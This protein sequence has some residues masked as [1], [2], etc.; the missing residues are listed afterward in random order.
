[1]HNRNIKIPLISSSPPTSPRSLSLS[2]THTHSFEINQV[3]VN[4]GGGGALRTAST[5]ILVVQVSSMKRGG[6]GVETQGVLECVDR[7]EGII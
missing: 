5:F 3:V 4:W 6:G 7:F 1:M 2:H